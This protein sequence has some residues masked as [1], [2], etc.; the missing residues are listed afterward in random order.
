ML[1]NLSAKTICELSG[2]AGGAVIDAAIRKA[3]SDIEDR[4]LEDGKERKVN[5]QIVMKK[6]A[7][8]TVMVDVVADASIPAFRSE[9]TR[10]VG[11]VR[12]GKQ[13]LLFQATNPDNTEQPTFPQMDAAGGEVPNE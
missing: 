10:A 3:V 8:D 7:E 5:I 1:E 9:P 11:R 2:G 12:E 6:I 4:G 13:Y